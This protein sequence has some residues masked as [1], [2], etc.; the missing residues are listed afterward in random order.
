VRILFLIP[1]PLNI[2]PGQRFRFEH[3]IN[4]NG[5]SNTYICRPF[6]TEAGW[7]ILHKKNNQVAKIVNIFKGIAK[8]TA[9]LFTLGQYDYVYVYREVAPLGP[10]VFE[11]LISKVFRKKIIY[12]FDDSIWIKIASPSNPGIAWLKCTWKVKHICKYS[13]IVTVGNSFLANYAKKYCNDVRI[14]PTVVNT[15]NTHNVIKD[16]DEMPLTIG[17]TCTYTNFYVFETIINPLN[18]LRENYQFEF[19]IIADRDPELKNFDYKFIK[20]DITTE[21]QDLVK[22]HVGVMPLFN[23]PVGL[24][25]CAFKAIQYMSLGIPPVVSPV[26]INCEVVTN[27]VNGFWASTEQEW[28]DKLEKLITNKELRVEMGL[29][30]RKEI[31]ARHSV[32][33]TRALFYELFKQ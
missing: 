27:N 19:L 33:A 13:K 17:W 20:W 16:H 4:D 12:D 2:S 22:L 7:S 11:W 24:G 14:I 9:L 5:A 28:Y 30:A 8:R 29:K 26:G 18:K 3:Y 1:A 6:F 21:V 15:E 23:T 10:P 32:I 31:V 25:K